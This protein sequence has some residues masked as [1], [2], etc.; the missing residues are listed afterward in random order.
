MVQ[1]SCHIR[2]WTKNG[3]S[4]GRILLSLP[5]GDR[6]TRRFNQQSLLLWPI[7]AL[8]GGHAGRHRRFG[9]W[10]L[11]RNRFCYRLASMKR[12]SKGWIYDQWTAAWIRHM[13]VVSPQP[14]TTALAA[15]WHK[16]VSNARTFLVEKVNFIAAA[17]YRSEWGFSS[18]KDISDEILM[19]RP[20]G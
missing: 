15:S 12:R 10:L 16:T 4:S 8:A 20:S 14:M 11:Q 9:L 6:L 3:G 19:L 5:C 7:G 13:N 17:L 1:Q 18:A 2:R